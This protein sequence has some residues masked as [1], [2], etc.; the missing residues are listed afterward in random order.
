MSEN[1]KFDGNIYSSLTLDPEHAVASE[2]LE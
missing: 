1:I 2:N